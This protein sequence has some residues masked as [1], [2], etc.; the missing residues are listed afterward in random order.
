MAVR[1]NVDVTD[2]QQVVLGWLVEQ[3]NAER[4]TRLTA[5][6]FVQARFAELMA[7]YD[8]RFEEW[9]S[10]EV[11]RRYK[12]GTLSPE[13]KAAIDADLDPDA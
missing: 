2:R 1:Y 10:E 3:L 6:Q 12:L 7:P 8:L 4:G 5:A 13:T 9:K 11:K